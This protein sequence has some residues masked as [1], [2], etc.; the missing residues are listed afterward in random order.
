MTPSP[1]LVV[2]DTLKDVPVEDE[3][4]K[5]TGDSLSEVT[6]ASR[7]DRSLAVP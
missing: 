7:A 4:P 1:R 5:F 3:G 6:F 2:Q